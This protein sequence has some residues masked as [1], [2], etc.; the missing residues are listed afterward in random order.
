VR[1]LRRILAVAAIAVCAP[2]SISLAGGAE[3]NDA[4]GSSSGDGFGATAGSGNSGDPSPGP[5]SSCAYEVPSQDDPRWK[6][7]LHDFVDEFRYEINGITYVARV[8]VCDGQPDRMVLFEVASS[9]AVLAARLHDEMWRRVPAPQPDLSPAGPGIVNLGMWLAVD[10]PDIPSAFARSG[11][12]WARVT[13]TLASTTFDFG[14]GDRTTCDGGGTAISALESIGEGPCGYTYTE[15]S[16][17]G[18]PFR[19]T[20]EMTWNIWLDSSGGSRV[21]APIRRSTTFDYDVFE[22]QT[23]GTG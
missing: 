15:R 21:L 18:A 23:V 17:S 14:N 16:A 19:I 12:N 4:G 8:K 13:P 1:N 3:T 9:V 6:D 7:F 20:V 2:S 22:I 11:S 10:V 5:N